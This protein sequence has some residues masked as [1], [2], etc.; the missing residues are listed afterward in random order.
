MN[1]SAN[2]LSC[3]VGNRMAKPAEGL[4]ITCLKILTRGAIL[5]SPYKLTPEQL[6]LPLPFSPICLP[7]MRLLP[8][9]AFLA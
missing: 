6:C 5:K 3:S 4:A 2:E 1:S 8:I 7:V 9:W